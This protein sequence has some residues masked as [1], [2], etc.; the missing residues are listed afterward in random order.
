LELLIKYKN[1]RGREIEIQRKTSV[2]EKNNG[3]EK[4][5]G[6]DKTISNTQTIGFLDDG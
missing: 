2:V 5:G 4:G 6:I 3:E 1:K